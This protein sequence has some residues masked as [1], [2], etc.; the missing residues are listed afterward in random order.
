MLIYLMVFCSGVAGLAYQVLWMRQLGLLFGNTS[1]AAAVTLG[2]FFLGL[3]VGSWVWGGRAARSRNPLRLYAQLE[4]GIAAT[5]LVYFVILALFRALYPSVY[6]SVESPAVLLLV[7]FAFALLLV[8]PPAFCMGGTIPAIGQYLIRRPEAFGSTSALLYAVNTLGAALGAFGTAFFLV[9][10]L[11]F[12]L[13]CA[14]AIAL[15]TG[16]GLIALRKSSGEEPREPQPATPAPQAE[17]TDGDAPPAA[18]RGVIYGLAFFSGFSVLALEVLW[19]RMFAQVHE[20]SVYSFALVL[21]IVLV[22]LAL[23]AGLSSM[24]ARSGLPPITTLGI[25]SLLSGVAVAFCPTRF[26]AETN[27]LAM[28]PTAESLGVYALHMLRIGAGSVGMVALILG[29]IFPYLM[30]AEERHALHPGLSLGRLAAINTAGAILGSVLC[31]F[32]FLEI[33]GLWRTMQLL[34]AGY[35]VLGIVLGPLRDLLSAVPKIIGV[36]LLVLLFTL[37]DPTNLPAARL[38]S[39]ETPVAVLESHGATV[40]VF[41]TSDGHRGLRV[42]S[43]YTLGSTVDFVNQVHQARVPLAIFPETRSLFFLGMGTG[44]TAG[45]S[46][47]KSFGVERVVV[48]ELSGAVVEAARTYLTD[49]KG[50]DFTLG[51]FDDPRVDILV[52]DGRQVLMATDE[53]F[54]MINADLFLP[55][56]SGTGSLY[57]LEHYTAAKERLNPGGVFVQWLPL[58]QVTEE[59]FGIITRTFLEVFPQVTLWRNRFQPGTEVVAL[60][61]QVDTGP[62]PGTGVDLHIEKQA[63]VRGM[64]YR[65]ALQLP[66]LF[67]ERPTL[68]RYAGNISAARDLFAKYPLNTDDKPLVEYLTPRS[69]RGAEQILPLQFLG[70]KFAELVDKIL[71]RT[72]PTSDRLLDNFSEADRHLPLAG[73]A[74]HKAG[75]GLVLRDRLSIVNPK[76]SREYE[77]MAQRQWQAFVRAWLHA[78]AEQDESDA[79]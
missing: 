20:N 16:I 45:G 56:R 4:F 8:F 28:I 71:E 7:K 10:R 46:L 58:Y 47:K 72:P 25:L 52:E 78:P 37:L 2:A 62:L 55:Y 5:A 68:L 63:L 11:G 41:D 54:D 73:A 39:G 29:T 32:V 36:A 79:E 3:A 30:K 15:S 43:N 48:C 42:N 1:H 19:T 33:F 17:T 31:G 44:A 23:G 76:Q 59:E 65:N 57:S 69:L 70:P 60:V 12:G 40:T 34:A 51:I 24:L 74:L 9:M 21:V 77:A 27:D 22:S 14:A 66:Q 26:M 67:T 13:T 50:R 49:Y 6:Q 64:T 75:V 18:G 35:L 53:T 61:G 38:P